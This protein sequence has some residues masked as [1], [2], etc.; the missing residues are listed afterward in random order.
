MN[1]DREIF[2]TYMGLG[3]KRVPH[4]EHWA[5]P[6]AETELTGINYYEHPRECRLRMAE[7]YPE[8]RLAIPETDAPIVRD[9]S[10]HTSDHTVR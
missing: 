9:T 5:N 4:W 8:L 3:P 7:L 2:E 1:Y 6:D 10:N